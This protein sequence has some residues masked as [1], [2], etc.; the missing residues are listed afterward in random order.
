MST[1]MEKLAMEAPLTKQGLAR[2][3]P[4]DQKE[5]LYLQT[6][7]HRKFLLINSLLL[8]HS[9]SSLYLRTAANDKEGCFLGINDP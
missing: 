5:H 3:Q 2:T 4:L 1:C 8:H 9:F 7:L 6:V